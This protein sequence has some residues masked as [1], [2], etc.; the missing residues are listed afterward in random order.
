MTWCN[1]QKVLLTNK[2]KQSKKKEGCFKLPSRKTHSSLAAHLPE[3][4][5][6][7]AVRHH[8]RP[9]PTGGLHRFTPVVSQGYRASKRNRNSKKCFSHHRR[10]HGL[11]RINPCY[12]PVVG[13][14]NRSSRL[15]VEHGHHKALSGKTHISR[16]NKS[17]KE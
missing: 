17:D 13:R 11:S 10:L 9:W 2:K 8:V 3:P 5:H 4:L 7:R 6:Q 14:L 1:L 16:S 12:V 15:H